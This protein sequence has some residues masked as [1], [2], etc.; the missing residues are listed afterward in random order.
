MNKRSVL[1]PAI[2]LLA[3]SILLTAC[4]SGS[5]MPTSSSGSP[6]SATYPSPTETPVVVLGGPLSTVTP[7]AGAQKG[8]TLPGNAVSVHMTGGSLLFVVLT[9]PK[10]AVFHC[11]LEAPGPQT[12]RVPT[13]VTVTSKSG[14]KTYRVSPS[15][16]LTPGPYILRF[17]GSG[18]F[19]M[20][21]Y[22]TGAQ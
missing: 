6:A 14:F 2:A 20:S 13:Q 8:R 4:G 7:R 16:P 12:R 3:A 9:V 17:G 22:E 5:S 21:V 10:T 1:G 19:Q 18:R 11:V 15:Q